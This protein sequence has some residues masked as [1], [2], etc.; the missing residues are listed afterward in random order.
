[1]FL[2]IKYINR[3]SEPLLLI[4]DEIRNKYLQE[5]ILPPAK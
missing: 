3:F 1:M 5:N 2:G 4:L